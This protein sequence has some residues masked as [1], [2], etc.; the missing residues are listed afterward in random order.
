MLWI[1]LTGSLHGAITKAYATIHRHTYFTGNNET[2][3]SEWKKLQKHR[4]SKIYFTLSFLS[5]PDI[6]EVYFFKIAYE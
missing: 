6:R 5:L 2:T 1:T 3:D 4:S